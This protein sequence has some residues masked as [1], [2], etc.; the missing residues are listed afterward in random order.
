M[1]TDDLKSFLD[2]E[3]R[4]MDAEVFASRLRENPEVQAVADDFRSI[5]QVLKTEAV[6]PESAGLQATLVRLRVS[7]TPRRS[8]IPA[9]SGGFALAAVLALVAIVPLY[10]NRKSMSDIPDGS[11][12][13]LES[14]SKSATAMELDRSAI[15]EAAAPLAKRATKEVAVAPRETKKDAGA[16]TLNDKKDANVPMLPNVSSMPGQLTGIDP[17]DPSAASGP[18]GEATIRNLVA[19]MKGKIVKS[20]ESSDSARAKAKTI[21]VSVPGD[22]ADLLVTRLRA[23]LSVLAE[24]GDPYDIPA[25]PTT[26]AVAGALDSRA[27]AQGGAKPETGAARKMDSVAAAEVSD[28]VSLPDLQSQMLLL[29]RRKAELLAQFFE[30][31]KPVQEV[32]GQVRDL[33]KKIDAKI[34][35]EKKAAKKAKY[36]QIVIGGW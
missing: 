15:P 6:A 30:D 21:L 35:A 20:T 32:E 7:P 27:D 36:I 11:F 33:Q 3:M 9:F 19:S 24:V 12:A 34:A 31:A 18:V 29:K 1:N 8:W 10:L 14:A 23:A 4:G 17:V 16:P 22:N 25:S 13:K 2:G 28:D 26:V 5:S